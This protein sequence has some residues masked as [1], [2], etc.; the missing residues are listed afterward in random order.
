MEGAFSGVGADYRDGVAV[1]QF[2][3]E[4]VRRE[5]LTGWLVDFSRERY[6]Y[7]RVFV[8]DEEAP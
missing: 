2:A 1:A 6:Y 8:A 4:G 3:S 7:L 5:L